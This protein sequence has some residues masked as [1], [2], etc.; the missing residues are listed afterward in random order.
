MESQSKSKKMAKQSRIGGP[1]KGKPY[2]I[3]DWDKV[4]QLIIQGCNGVQVAAQLG[5]SADTLYDRCQN[6]KNT[7]FPVYFQ[8]KRAMGDSY[9]HQ[10]QY[11]KALK[12]KNTTMLI[13][14]GKQR[15]GQKDTEVIAK[16]TQEENQTHDALLKQIEALQLSLERSI[17]DKSKSTDN[18]S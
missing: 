7:H 17:A 11:Q 3:I 12:E 15:C 8:E 5:I 9:I 14:L 18:K 1:K 13:W 6:E 2:K 10:A 16:G 4:D